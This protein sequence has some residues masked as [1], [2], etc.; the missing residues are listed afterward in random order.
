VG[1]NMKKVIVSMCVLVVLSTAAFGQTRSRTTRRGTQTSKTAKPVPSDTVVAVKA[2]GATR[3]ATEIKSLTTFLY[4][5]GGVAKDLDAQTAAAK[6]GTSSPT[7]ERNVAKIT[8]N[9]ED[10]RVG[11]ESLETYFSSTSELRPYYAKLLGSADTA[12]SAKSQAATGHVDQA[13]H[14]LLSIVN[15]LTDILATMR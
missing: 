15:R 5:L 6:S 4:L 10:F 1:V 2:E 8:A 7:Q 3:I 11:L 13:G 14:T 12:A 9:F